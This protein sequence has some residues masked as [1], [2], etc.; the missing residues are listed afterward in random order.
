VLEGF[1]IPPTGRALDVPRVSVE[2][3]V[4]GVVPDLV[5]ARVEA[6]GEASVGAELIHLPEDR[7]DQ[8]TMPLMGALTP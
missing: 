4:S 5:L 8:L 1:A 3:V 6:T 7:M 2:D